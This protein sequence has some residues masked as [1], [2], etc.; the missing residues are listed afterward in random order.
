MAILNITTIALIDVLMEPIYLTRTVWRVL[1]NVKLV[2]MQINAQNVR[3]HI[4][5]TTI[6]VFQN[7]HPTLMLKMG[8]ALL[9]K[10]IVLLVLIRRRIV[11]LVN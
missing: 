11:Y 9:V 2:I 4:I 5:S 7:V 10:Q 8:F 1:Q 6:N 3:N